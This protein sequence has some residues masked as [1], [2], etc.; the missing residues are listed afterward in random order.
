MENFKLIRNS[1]TLIAIIFL[2]YILQTDKQKIHLNANT[3]QIATDLTQEKE[4]IQN[5]KPASNLIFKAEIYKPGITRSEI[6]K[7]NFLESYAP[8]NF[9][10]TS[11]N[12]SFNVTFP[13]V[14]APLLPARTNDKIVDERRESQSTKKNENKNIST[15]PSTILSETPIKNQ[16]IPFISIPSSSNDQITHELKNICSANIS[17]GSFGHPI[18]ITLSCSQNSVIQYCVSIDSG[19]GCC[20]PFNSGSLYT[21]KIGIGSENADYCLSYYGESST[22]GITDVYQNNYTINSQLPDLQIGHQMIQY[23]TTQLSGKIYLTSQDFGKSGYAMGLINLK[24]HDP[25]PAAT[26]L[27]CSDI[28]EFNNLTLTPTPTEI[29]SL[30]DVSLENPATQLDILLNPGHLVYGENYVTGYMLND[31]YDL[32]LYSCST[33]LITLLDFDFFDYQPAF[34]DSGNN[35]VREFSGSLTSFGF[36][37]AEDDIYRIPAG[38]SSEEL[39]GQKLQYGLLGIFY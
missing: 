16:P 4:S 15:S 25:S 34:G 11:K 19:N 2:G 29:L 37:E 18:G 30:L 8:N 14:G 33:S 32:P 21:S 38:H 5:R 27:K 26:N 6:K 3:P 1:A 10:Q 17:G 9:D 12:D 20:D 28:V 24:N 13:A 36:F 39:N 31:N 23:Q 35:T 7:S 22:S